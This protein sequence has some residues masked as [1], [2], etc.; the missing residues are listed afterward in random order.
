M[1]RTLTLI[2]L[3]ACS[4]PPSTPEATSKPEAT[5]TPAPAS[6]PKRAS[7][8]APASTAPAP[9]A[10]SAAGSGT[11]SAVAWTAPNPTTIP[12]GPEGDAIRRGEQIA[13]FTYREL[14]DHVGASISCSNCHLDAG[15]TPGAFPWVGVT[16]RYPKYRPRRG[17]TVDLAGRINGCFERSL[18]GEPL[19]PTA[20]P[21]TDLIAY[22]S[23][24]S[25]DVSPDDKLAGL[26]RTEL[27]AP[28][29]PDATRGAAVFAAKCQACHQA[30][31]QGLTAPDGTVIYPPLWGDSSF[32]IAAGMARHNTAVSFVYEVM[33]LGQ[34]RSLTAQE[35]HDVAA[36]F[37]TKPRPDFAAK[38]H[39]WPKGGKPV[40]A[41]Y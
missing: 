18:N 17:E 31:G 29:P 5:S 1:L 21:M 41:R 6:A 26:G 20:Q 23:W 40:D 32:N 34:P 35:T 28:E 38:I 30:G 8:P 3:A 9:G 13:R 7:A 10:D 15:R 11:D 19:E 4:T 16:H 14:P 22:M 2:A 37:T 33:P 27:D 25:R 39:D 24:L 12:E 36:Y